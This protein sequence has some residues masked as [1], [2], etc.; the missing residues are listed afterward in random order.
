MNNGGNPTE[1]PYEEIERALGYKFSDKSLLDAA[2]T[3]P[4]CAK[5]TSYQRLEFL[6][7]AVIG[8]IV[9]D[10]LYRTCDA[11]EGG[12][13]RLRSNYVSKDALTPVSKEMGLIRFLRYAGGERNL[14]EKV[15]SDL[16]EA[17]T[18][19]IYLDGGIGAA[20]AFLENHLVYYEGVNYR[21]LVQELVQGELGQEDPPHY[22]TKE[23][24]GGFVCTATACGKSA[25]GKGKNKK[26]AENSAAERLY[27]LLKKE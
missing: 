13:T 2:F 21:P 18:A 8:Y 17:V 14:G 26:S 3:H 22:E 12:L 27:K 7:D 1:R 16:F 23:T 5:E 9:A 19:A 6:G 25:E 24:D 15:Y 20:R 11:E 10:Q 4:S